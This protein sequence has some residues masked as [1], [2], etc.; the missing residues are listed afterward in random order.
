PGRT[1]TSSSS[2]RPSARSR[3]VTE[4]RAPQRREVRQRLGGGGYVVDLQAVDGEARQRPG[5]RHPVIGVG[6]PPAAV[7]LPW[8]DS[9]R[10][11]V[12]DDVAAETGQLRRERGEP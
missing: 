11:V 8:G 6:T 2:R 5:R 4:E 7:Q 12:R 9:Q 3:L 10:V 1:R